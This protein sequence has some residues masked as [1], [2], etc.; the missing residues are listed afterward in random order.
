MSDF[1]AVKDSGTRQE[2]ST[3]SKRDSR[4]GKGRYDLITPLGLRRLAIHYENGAKKYGDHNWSKG[5]PICRYLD[6]AIRHAYCYLSG[7]R[8]EDHLAA[9]AWNALSAIHTEEAVEIGILPPELDDT[10]S[11][12]NK[13]EF[14]KRIER[15]AQNKQKELQKEQ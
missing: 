14:W 8:D 9:V 1:K 3:G 6:S 11:Y 4:A 10:I 12:K 7:A 15:L 5:Q 13:E 2:F